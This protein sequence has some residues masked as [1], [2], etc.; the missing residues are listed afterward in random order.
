MEERVGSCILKDGWSGSYLSDSKK[1]AP[2]YLVGVWR[3]L[4]KGGKIKVK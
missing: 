3:N 2:R 1:G 4:I